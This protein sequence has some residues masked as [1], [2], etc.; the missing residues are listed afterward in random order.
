MKK[1]CW[2]VMLITLG[3][4]AAACGGGT[5]TGA[6]TTP[7]A[8]TPLATRSVSPTSSTPP[9]T[10]SGTTLQIATAHPSPS[11]DKHCLAA[12]ANTAFQIDFD[13]QDGGVEH[14]VSIYTNAGA[15]TAL[16]NGEIIIGPKKITYQVMALPAGTYYFRCD[17][18]PFGTMKGTFVVGG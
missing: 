18:H 6:V 2:L 1:T 11:Y 8:T 3:M 16:L 12:P 7:S 9:C 5:K 17:V 10:P 4:L 15:G 14:N 13:N